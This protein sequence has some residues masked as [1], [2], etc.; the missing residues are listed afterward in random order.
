MRQ[1]TMYAVYGIK[2]AKREYGIAGVLQMHLY[3]SICWI[4]FYSLPQTLL[5]GR[6]VPRLADHEWL[7]YMCRA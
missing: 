7:M 2:E 1:K 6:P 5:A 3:A 4:F